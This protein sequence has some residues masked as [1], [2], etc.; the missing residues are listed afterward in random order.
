VITLFL[1]HAFEDK[2]DFVRPLAEALR[3]DFNVWYD[4]YQLKMGDSLL[5]KIT[6]G[7]HSCD[8]GVVV[9]SAQFFSKR[10]PKTELDGLFAL[11]ATER[12]VILPIWKGVSEKEVREFSPILAGRLGVSSDRGLDNVILEIKVAVGLVDRY[13]DLQQTAYKSKFALLNADIEH[14]IAEETRGSTADGVQQVVTVA[15]DIIVEARQRSNDLIRDINAFHLSMLGD[16]RKVSQDSLTVA[17]PRRISMHLSYYAEYTNSVRHF[18][19]TVGFF[20]NKTVFDADSEFETI[21]EMRFTPRFD[22]ELK[23]Y[24]E[25][26]SK[27]FSTGGALLDY[28]FERFADLLTEELQ[29]S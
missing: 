27:R 1:S 4:E 17:G 14:R 2:E 9:L 18:R 7:L 16:A 12:K 25:H 20:R 24:W 6:E 3:V 19:F 15:R 29:N 22:R 10:W 28:A 8:Y 23:V 5:Q 11:E 26:P 13:K 21:D